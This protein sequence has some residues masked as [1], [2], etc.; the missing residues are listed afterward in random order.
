[1]K[2]WLD[3]KRPAPKGWVRAYTPEEVIT[4]LKTGQ[5]VKLSLDHDLGG[6]ETIG[7]GMGILAWLEEQVAL[8]GFVPPAYIN[9]HTDNGPAL[10][11]MRQAIESI[12]RLAAM[13]NQKKGQL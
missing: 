9:A 11:R 4:H 7:T 12:E 3:D 8:H 5:V 6:D 2:V 1:M 10:A 13:N